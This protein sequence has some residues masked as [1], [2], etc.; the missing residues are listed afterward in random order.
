MKLDLL[1]E[2]N[3]Q[4]IPPKDFMDTFCKRCRNKTCVNAGWSKSSFE[5]RVATQADRLLVNPRRAGS[6]D[7]RFV[8]I[9]AQHFVEIAEA[10]ILA[11]RE[12]PWAGP[13]VHL[14][15]PDSAQVTSAVV[16]D[17]VAKLS[18]ARGKKAPVEVIPVPATVPTPPT[19]PAPPVQI[20]VKDP[21]TSFAMN[22]GFPEEGVML[23][24]DPLPAAP[25][26]APKAEVIDPWTPAPKMNVVPR[27]AKI[28]MEG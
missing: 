3:D 15:E 14:A 24:G 12:D 4:H 17:A 18:E 13:G 11:K 9:R 1:Q 28:K 5:E 21:P 25:A 20:I 27:G 6:D 7:P 10:I 22:T 23:G 2:C 8:A 16:E 26:V 19:V